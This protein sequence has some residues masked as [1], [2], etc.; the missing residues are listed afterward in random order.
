MGERVDVPIAGFTFHLSLYYN[1]IIFHRVAPFVF[2]AVL[3]EPSPI[4]DETIRTV[5][6]MRL[7]FRSEIEIALSR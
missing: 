5:A 7:I 3:I 2:H 1:N 4:R 6:K